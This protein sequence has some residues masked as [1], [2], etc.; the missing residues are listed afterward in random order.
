MPQGTQWMRRIAEAPVLALV[1][2]VQNP[3]NGWAGC[4]HEAGNPPAKIGP[5]APHT[6]DSDKRHFAC[7]GDDVFK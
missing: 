7:R 2:N 6:T 5:I 1:G 3:F 4:V